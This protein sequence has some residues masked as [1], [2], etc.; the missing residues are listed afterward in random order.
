MDNRDFS[1]LGEQIRRTVEDAM[2]SMNYQQ[3]NQKINQTVDMAMNEA[4]RH[5]HMN[6]HIHVQSPEQEKK[7]STKP[8]PKT[9]I[10][11]KEKGRYISIPFIILG[12]VGLLVFTGILLTSIIGFLISGS[13]ITKTVSSVVLAIGIM[14]CAL[15]IFFLVKGVSGRKRYLCFKKYVEIL[16]KRE[17]CSVKELSEKTHMPEKK[18]CKN[19]KS[20]IKAGM[21]LD[22]FLDDS[23]TCFTVT[24]EAYKQLMQAE[25]SRRQREEEQ[26]RRQE[27]MK[28]EVENISDRAV[29]EMIQKG[30]EYIESIRVA[31]DAIPGEIISAKLDRLENVVRKIFESVKQHPEQMPEM[32]KFMEYY[33]PTTQKL[34]N[35]YKEFD[36][37]DIKGENVTKSMNEIENT[38]DTIS[39][40]FEQL[41]D[42]LFQNTAFDI[43]ADISVLQTM[44]AREGYKEKDFK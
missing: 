28:K 34:V 12:G 35:A 2:D 24:T 27:A 23:Q 8:K 32:D 36:A 37:L 41:L 31:N 39:N 22:G 5:M 6:P 26:R 13:V 7:N 30:N 16:N 44:L 10:R 21:F 42:D 38:L 11:L 9:Q 43:S 29:V 1:N 15:S 40:A 20:M 14:I 19:L 3:L 17:F 33:L 18:V 25:E 4:R